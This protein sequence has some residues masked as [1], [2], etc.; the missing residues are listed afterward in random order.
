MGWTCGWMVF[1]M[2][3]CGQEEPCYPTEKLGSF[4]EEDYDCG[5]FS[6]LDGF[7]GG[8]CSNT[9][10]VTHRCPEDSHCIQIEFAG[11][12]DG[13]SGEVCLAACGAGLPPCRDGYHCR[14]IDDSLIQVCF[15]D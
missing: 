12:G 13:L 5:E 4:C 15:P 9:C 6:C 3:G 11:S 10:E 8:Y 2:F 7:P 1:F 14:K